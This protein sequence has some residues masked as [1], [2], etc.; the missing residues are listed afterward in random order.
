MHGWRPRG[1]ERVPF[2]DCEWESS[3]Q[4][5]VTLIRQ[6]SDQILMRCYI[7]VFWHGKLHTS[8]ILYIP[9]HVQSVKIK[10]TNNV[11]LWIT[12]MCIFPCQN[13]TVTPKIATAFAFPWQSR[14][15]RPTRRFK[16]RRRRSS[17]NKR[18]KMFAVCAWT[19]IAVFSLSATGVWNCLLRIKAQG[20]GVNKGGSCTWYY[21]RDL[22][23]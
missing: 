16:L 9:V 14:F 13:M 23:I 15:Q 12:K 3:I 20:I 8:F 19:Q 2:H 17:V 21:I 18:E 4:Y 10:L 6:S 5:H 22:T 11:V 7:K 1:M